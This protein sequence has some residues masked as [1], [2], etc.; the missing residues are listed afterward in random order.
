MVSYFEWVQN[1]QMFMWDE[2]QVNSKLEKIMIKAFD[3]VWSM[4]QQEKVTLRMAA[5]MVALERVVKT[6]KIRG[7]F[8]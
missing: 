1:N 4:H 2:E 3:G 7:I 5:Y 6:K 8:P